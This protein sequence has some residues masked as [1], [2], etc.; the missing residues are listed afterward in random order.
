M[1][2]T[3]PAPDAFGNSFSAIEAVH[4]LSVQS[5]FKRLTRPIYDK[6]RCDKKH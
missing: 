6:L 4:R 2:G 3:S 5:H 1:V